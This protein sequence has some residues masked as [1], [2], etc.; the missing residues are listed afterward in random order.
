MIWEAWWAWMAAG[1]VLGILE[2]LLP[3]FL[4]LGFA[5][6]AVAM[7]LLLLIGGPLAAFVTGSLA[8]MLA[9]FAVLSVI[10]WLVLRAV[11]RVP[12]GNVK[13]FHKDI[14]ED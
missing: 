4:A 11:F 6:G 13:V 8:A 7:G 9:A 3:G 10:A 14:N 2:L 5:L 1:L 12:R